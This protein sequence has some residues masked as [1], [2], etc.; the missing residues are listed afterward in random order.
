[1]AQI[2][3]LN[4]KR[5]LSSFALAAAIAATPALAQQDQAPKKPQG[6]TVMKTFAGWDVRC[7][8][9]TSPAPCDVWEATAYKNTGQFAVSVSI[10]YVPS[11]N[12]YFMQL[13]VPL[14]MDLQKGAKVVSGSYQSDTLKYHHCDRLGCYL[15]VPQAGQ[16]VGTMRSAQKVAVRVTAYRG[17][18]GDLDI[19]LKGFGDAVSSMVEYAR[20]KTSGGGSSAAPAPAAPTDGSNP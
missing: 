2:V 7:F 10:A 1:V 3:V 14:G 5:L 12:Q 19:P 8:S 18:S 9:T 11:Q 4:M 15:V 16:I 17:K 6:P 20:Q 13:V